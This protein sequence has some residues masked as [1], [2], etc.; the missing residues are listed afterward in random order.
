VRD[1]ARELGVRYVLEGSVRKS[2]DKIRITAQLLEGETGSQLWAD[3]FGGALDD[4]FDMQDRVTE[5]VVAIVEPRL[6]R[7]EIERARRK[8]PER[9]DAYDLYLRSL[10][11]VYSTRPGPINEAIE[12]LE[13]A[14]ARDPNF[15][16]APMMASHAY[17]LRSAMQLEG[18]QDDDAARSIAH[19]RRALAIAGDDPAVLAQTGFVLVHRAREYEEGFALLRRAVAE[20]PNSTV[21]LNCIGVS[22]LL[23]GDLD[24]GEAFLKHAVELNPN[25]MGVHWELTG[26]AHIQII[27]GRYEDALVFAGRS[28]AANPGYDPTHWMLIAANAYLGRMDVARRCVEGLQSI[29]PG[30]TL[31]RIRRGQ[32]ARDPH[33]IDVVIEGIR[34]AGLPE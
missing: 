11:G 2:V 26:I 14:A 31:S 3:R 33:R 8:H 1:V 7:A 20:N 5:N 34:M 19:A 4:I 18:T 10:P 24:E 30:V 9:L 27:Q 23:G 16:L 12:L 15:A 22:S 6:K 21:V 28:L 29:S 32:H 17:L 13:R 25:D